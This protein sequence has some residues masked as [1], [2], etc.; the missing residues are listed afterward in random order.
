MRPDDA[1]SNLHEKILRDLIRREFNRICEKNPLFSLRAL[2]RM[3]GISHSTLS[4]VLSG[5]RRLSS[6]IS[7][8]LL[9]T[10]KLDELKLT[11]LVAVGPDE[12]GNRL[13]SDLSTAHA[14]L[15]DVGKNLT[16]IATQSAP[17]CGGDS[18]EA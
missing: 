9:R 18:P 17:I 7:K 5:K 15:S 12:T 3:A 8:R 14:G 11:V 2:A 10:L 1:V 6:R 16:V 13:I 4:E